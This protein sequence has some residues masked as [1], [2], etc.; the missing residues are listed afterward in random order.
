MKQIKRSECVIL[1]LVLKGKWYDMIASGEKKEEYRD[2]KPYYTTRIVNWHNK[3]WPGYAVVEFRY[4]YA[5]DAERMAFY[6]M[7]IIGDDPEERFHCAIRNESLHP[8]W[9]EPETP[10]FVIQLGERV[11]L[12]D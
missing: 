3:M 4:G 10:H 11:E 5:R 1:P 6:A 12:V 8:E 2:L 7:R 9:G